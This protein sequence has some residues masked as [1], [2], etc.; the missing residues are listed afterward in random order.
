MN[1]QINVSTMITEQPT[2]K[3]GTKIIVAAMFALLVLSF[4]VVGMQAVYA[5]SCHGDC[6]GEGD[7][8]DD[9]ASCTSVLGIPII[10]P[11]S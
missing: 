8:G 9:D 1:N 3:L 2:K 7:G 4:G 6:D 10:C 5:D 11:G